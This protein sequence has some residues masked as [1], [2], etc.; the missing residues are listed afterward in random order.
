MKI[1]PSPNAALGQMSGERPD[2][3]IF[4]TEVNVMRSRNIAAAVVDKLNLG[5][6]TALTKG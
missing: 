1:D 3:N 2:Q 6:N 4:D 5:G